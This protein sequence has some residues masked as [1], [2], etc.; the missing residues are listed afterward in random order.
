VIATWR[1]KRCNSIRFFPYHAECIMAR[2]SITR[3]WQGAFTLIE[4]LVVIA[5]I[6][7][8]IA[9][10]VPAVQKVREAAARAQC[11][12]NLKQIALGV[13]NTADTYKGKLP[14]GVGLYPSDGSPA[15]NNGDGGLLFHILPF[16]E[17]NTLYKASFYGTPQGQDGRNS[18]L[19]VY[20]Q[21]N[22][23][24]QAAD[25][26]IYSCPSDPTN[27]NPWG[28]TAY[29]SYAYNGMIFRHNYR[30]GVSLTRYPAQLTDGTSNTIMMMD[31][32]RNVSGGWYNERF[33]PDWGGT[34]Y[35]VLDNGGIP[36]GANSRIMTFR[37]MNPN[38]DQHALICGN[39]YSNNQCDSSAGI[40]PHN[41]VANV[42]MC[43][44][45][46]QTVAST[47]SGAVLWAALTPNAGD[48]FSGFN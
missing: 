40:T 47:I 7:I 30:W 19:A 3:K 15:I 23:T 16:V 22:G 39:A 13:V 21:W 12:N 35:D 42:A 36:S 10:L 20:T 14:P 8:L 2:L 24:I 9:L 6:A 32:L 33:W 34:A 11:V 48:L 25:V 44:G 31:G 46:V 41:G 27:R 17:Q 38:G 26:P 18:N 28:S 5:I 43:D 1:L 29:T 4:L 37:T 45:S